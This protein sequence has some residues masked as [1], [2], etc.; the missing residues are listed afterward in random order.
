MSLNIQSN[1][2]MPQNQMAFKSNVMQKCKTIAKNQ[3]GHIIT[4]GLTWAGLEAI[5]PSTNLM[6]VIS[7]KLCIDLGEVI[8][9]KLHRTP[10]TVSNAGLN[11]FS[12][13]NL[14]KT[15]VKNLF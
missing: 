9:H 11:I 7:R 8:A 2:A 13:I 4:Q 10:T 6:E 1:A 15:Q 5:F 14:L 3:E 12:Y